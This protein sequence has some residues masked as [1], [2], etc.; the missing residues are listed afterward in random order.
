VVVRGKNGIHSDSGRNYQLTGE[1]VTGGMVIHTTGNFQLIDEEST[2]RM[3][4]P[5]RIA[6]SGANNPP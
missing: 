5:P 3:V 1:E 4:I 6:S 2:G